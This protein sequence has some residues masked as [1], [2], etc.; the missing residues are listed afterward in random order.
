MGLIAGGGQLPLIVARGLR[1]IGHPVHGLGLS[2]Q[3]EPDLPSLCSSFRDV[4]L[5]R[6]GSWGRILSKMGVRHAIM[7][8]RVDKAKVMHDPFRVF[9]YLPDFRTALLWLTHLRHDRRSHAVLN[10]IADELDRCGVSLLDSTAPIPQELASAG[11]MTR[12]LPT[13]EQRR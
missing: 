11:V 13:P 3:Y 10:A 1:Q 4:G 5:L 6:V 2:A 9:R 7:V 12:R 8:G